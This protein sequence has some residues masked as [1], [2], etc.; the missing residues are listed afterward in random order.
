MRYQSSFRVSG[1]VTTTLSDGVTRFIEDAPVTLERKFPDRAWRRIASTKANSENG[2]YNFFGTK[3]LKNATYR[4]RY[5]GETR[6]YETADGPM[7]VTFE[8]SVSPHRV[9]RV[10]RAFNLSSAKRNGSFYLNGRVLPEYRRKVVYVQ[11]KVCQTCRWRA[12]TKVRT[13]K[14]A[15]FSVR[16]A[17]PASGS[18]YYRAKTPRHKNFI[19]STSPRF[20]RIYRY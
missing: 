2:L 10:A 7:E 12:Y 9:I 16:V 8:P 6:S 5:A 17:T 4:V 13:N 1:Q 18:W 14:R 20:L 11:R 19:G 3:A 15:R